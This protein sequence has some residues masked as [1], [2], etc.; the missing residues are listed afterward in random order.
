MSGQLA[1]QLWRRSNLDVGANGNTDTPVRGDS[2]LGVLYLMGLHKQPQGA[3]KLQMG[4][5]G[6]GG[7][8]LTKGMQPGPDG[9]F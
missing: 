2:G 6:P 5:P 7:S 4:I 3:P 8:D 1:G 9:A